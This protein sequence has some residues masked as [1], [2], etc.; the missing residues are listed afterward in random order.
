MYKRSISILACTAFM[1]AIGL[2]S[3]F[4]YVRTFVISDDAF[5]PW[6]SISVD[7][8]WASCCAFLLSSM[9]ARLGH[10]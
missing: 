4:V 10:T 1:L 2:L 3:A 6:R 9:F 7:T 5:D 8:L